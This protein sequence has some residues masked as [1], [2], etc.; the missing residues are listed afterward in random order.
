M[1]ELFAPL[2]QLLTGVILPNLKN[3][4]LSQAEQI[5]ANDRL[6]NAIEELRLHLESQFAHLSAQLTACRAEVAATQAAFL[7]VQAKHGLLA[8][9]RAPLIH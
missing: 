5:A 2:T 6:E 7:A 3:V 8:P 1:D 9:E 4:Q